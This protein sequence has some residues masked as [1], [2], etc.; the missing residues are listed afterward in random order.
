MIHLAHI[1]LNGSSNVQKD[2]ERGINYL[3]KSSDYSND[4][5]SFLLGKYYLEGMHVKKDLS[6]TLREQL[7]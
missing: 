4:K 3:V 1:F 5:A 6:I 2:I 7:K